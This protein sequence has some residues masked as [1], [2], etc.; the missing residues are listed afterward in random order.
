MLEILQSWETFQTGGIEGSSVISYSSA[1][2]CW[3]HLLIV[4]FLGSNYGCKHV[5]VSHFRF[6]TVLTT[7]VIDS[8]SAMTKFSGYYSLFE[9]NWF[10]S[11]TVVATSDTV[12]W[13]GLPIHNG[14]HLTSCELIDGVSFI[15]TYVLSANS[16]SQISPVSRKH[17]KPT[18]KLTND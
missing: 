3:L 18:C 10:S 5:I 16:K 14:L 17:Q 8:D 12:D 6:F 4:A 9:V 13:F 2:F 7:V 11:K 15:I 1:W